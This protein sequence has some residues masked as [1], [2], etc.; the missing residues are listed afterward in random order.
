[1]S[2]VFARPATVLVQ[3]Q[4][5]LSY[6]DCI[7]RPLVTAGDGPTPLVVM[8]TK[9]GRGESK[10]SAAAASGDDGVTCN[11]RLAS[12]RLSRRLLLANMP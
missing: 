6:D 9:L 4:A 7:Q 1:M 2:V 3:Q 8:Q 12:A 10:P 11:N 5:L